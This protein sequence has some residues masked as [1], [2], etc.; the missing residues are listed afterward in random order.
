MKK[1]TKTILVGM[2]L[3]SSIGLWACGS[4]PSDP[5]D[6]Y[7]VYGPP[8]SGYVKATDDDADN[9]EAD[10]ADALSFTFDTEEYRA[11][12]EKYKSLQLAWCSKNSLV[13]VPEELKGVLGEPDEVYE[14]A[15]DASSYVWYF[16]GGY[17]INVTYDCRDGNTMEAPSEIIFGYKDDVFGFTGDPEALASSSDE[18]WYGGLENLSETV[19]MAKDVLLKTAALNYSQSRDNILNNLLGPADYFYGSG[20]DY[21]GWNNG[22]FSLVLA[23]GYPYKISGKEEGKALLFMDSTQYFDRAY[24]RKVCRCF[25]IKST[26]S[27]VTEILGTPDFVRGE[28]GSPKEEGSEKCYTVGNYTIIA[29]EEDYGLRIA[30]ESSD[31][32]YYEEVLG[33]SRYAQAMFDEICEMKTEKQI[34]DRFGLPDYY[35]MNKYSGKWPTGCYRVGDY[36]VM[37]CYDG[38]RQEDD[39]SVITHELDFYMGQADPKMTKYSDRELTK[40][41]E[42]P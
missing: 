19:S 14:K 35:I 16:D 26:M 20:I 21:R 23:N 12:H 7:S 42:E 9:K 11:A 36:E 1:P 41:I 10:S 30:F 6:S 27:D 4:E 3:V 13:F 32:E 34:E 29:S 2:A 5:G 28:E 39:G 38:S 40:V 15:A 22:A 8:P 24:A 33:N 17:Y 31:G 18:S 37:V 25:D